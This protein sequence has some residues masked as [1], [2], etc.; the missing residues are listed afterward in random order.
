MKNLFFIIVVS[1]SAFYA[2]AQQ[3]VKHDIHNPETWSVWDNEVSFSSNPT[4]VSTAGIGYIHIAPIT[5][6]SKG[7]Y[8]NLGSPIKVYVLEDGYI[9]P[10]YPQVTVLGSRAEFFIEGR[11]GSEGK[12]VF[13]KDGSSY[14]VYFDPFPIPV[15][16]TVEPPNRMIV[17]PL[18]EAPPRIPWKYTMHLGQSLL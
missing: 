14:F 5:R 18:S 8:R 10:R 13:N 7:A 11:E 3:Q 2:S 1:L 17:N 4:A 15:F 9:V 6:D 12:W 16:Q